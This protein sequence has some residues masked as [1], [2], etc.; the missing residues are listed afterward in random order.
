MSVGTQVTSGTE[1]N[2]VAESSYEY[3]LSEILAL[4]PPGTSSSVSSAGA[5][6]ASS[7]TTAPGGEPSQADTDMIQRL[8]AMGYDV[9]Y[10]YVEKVVANQ[11]LLGIEPLDIIKYICKEFWE[12]I[13]RKKID[14]LQTNHKGVFV[15]SD[16]K[17]KWLERY[18][19]DD[20]TSKQAAAR[21]LHFPC[22]ILRGALANLGIVAVVNADFN[23]LPAVTFNIR[24]KAAV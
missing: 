15:L 8:D 3:L 6:R 16:F 23:I 18:S 24:A 9:G 20:M 4:S 12:D 11:F 13:F 14:K 5:A 2:V 7:L 21:L 17:F 10:R 19:S 22:G 1:K